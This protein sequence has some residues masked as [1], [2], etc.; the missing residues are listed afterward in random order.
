[1]AKIVEVRE[2]KNPI[3]VL[4]GH[5]GCGK[6]YLMKLVENNIASQ[7][8]LNYLDFYTK[9]L[10]Y[11]LSINPVTTDWKWIRRIDIDQKLLTNKFTLNYIK[12]EISKDYW[13]K[14]EYID[15]II[16]NYIDLPSTATM[17][18]IS[19]LTNFINNNINNLDNKQ[20]IYKMTLLFRDIIDRIIDMSVKDSTFYILDKLFTP[21]LIINSEYKERVVYYAYRENEVLY[22][23]ER[24]NAPVVFIDMNHDIRS[25]IIVTK[26]SDYKISTL[27]NE[28]L[29]QEV[30]RI[31]KLSTYIINNDLD[32]E[33]RLATKMYNLL[34]F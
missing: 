22:F 15:Y 23:K 12:D 32:F 18:E 7:V 5:D 28:T 24:F 4:T 13:M 14:N 16:K 20:I 30:G 26:K 3:I 9:I 10:L 2:N 34:K 21:Y 27:Y 17:P 19:Q 8:N 33:N 6:S 1:M 25:Q 29:K 31:K 11:I